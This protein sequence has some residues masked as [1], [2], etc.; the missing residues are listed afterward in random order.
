MA[1]SNLQGNPIRKPCPETTTQI[2]HSCPQRRQKH[3]LLR[4]LKMV[5][6]GTKE[7]KAAL[8]KRKKKMGSLI[9]KARRHRVKQDHLRNL[10]RRMV[11]EE[12]MERFRWPKINYPFLEKSSTEPQPNQNLERRGKKRK[13]FQ[14][15]GERGAGYTTTLP[16]PHLTSPHLTSPHLTSPHLT[17][18]H[19]T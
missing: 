10:Q 12:I 7:T 3:L 17:S 19:L 14:R 8:L 1:P 15:R 4:R 2:G 5:S 13:G 18:P 6:D 11:L 16:T 9:I